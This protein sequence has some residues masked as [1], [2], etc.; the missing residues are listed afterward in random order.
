MKMRGG[1]AF[2]LS[3]GLLLLA[4]ASVS[5]ATEIEAGARAPFAHIVVAPRAMGFGVVK[6]VTS[7]MIVMRNS[8]TLAANV[9]VGMTTPSTA[10]S[11][12]FGGGSYTLSPGQ[13]QGIEVQYAPIAAG[14]VTAT[15]T[16][17]CSN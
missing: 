13:T 16:V 3:V 7:K 2:V 8:G 11:V 10:F 4:S 12:T 9:N 5:H 1:I 14:R 17:T 6:Q 15:L